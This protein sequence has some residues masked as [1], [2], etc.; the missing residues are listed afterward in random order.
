[1]VLAFIAVLGLI[2]KPVWEGRHQWLF[3][4]GYDDGIY[5]ATAKSLA[6]GEGYRQAGVPWS[7]IATKY[8]PLYPLYLSL[9]WRLEPH[10]PQTLER[11]AILQDALLPV[12]L[13]VL[14]IVL[15]QLRLSW[16]RTFFVAAMTFVSITFVFLTIRLFSELLFGCFLLA[17]IGAIEAA[18]EK[19]S[20][21]WATFGGLLA[22]LAYLTRNAALPL[23][24]A[25]P[26]FLFFRK[27]SRFTGYFLALALPMA[28]GWHVWGLVHADRGVKAPYVHE[29]WHW[30]QVGGFG[31]RLMT[32]LS[33]LS[34]AVANDFIPGLTDFLHGIPLHHLV[35]MA[36]IAGGIRLGKR[37]HWPLAM[38]FT[39]LYLIMIL[40]WWF[41]GM[42]RLMAPVLPIL[43][44]G[45]TEEGSYVARM[46]AHSIK[47][48]RFKAA[49]RWVMIALAVCLV[50]GD[51][52]AMWH[53]AAAEYALW[54]EHRKIDEQAY[55]WISGHVTPGTVLFAWKDTV[56]YLYTGVPSSHDLFVA[57]IPQS[58]DVNYKPIWFLPPGQFKSASLLLLDSD[59][60]EGFT[61]L[62]PSFQRRV[63]AVGG[64]LE[65][66]APG[67]FVYRVPLP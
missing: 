15:R 16:R 55:A 9:A 23:L 65:F 30:V 17:A 28:A 1:M 61:F 51:D 42:D 7:P 33:T 24:L 60:G 32:Q 45:I 48:A 18:V 25:V 11:A 49:P 38:I 59:F 67:A 36:A 34:A 12:Y 43:L 5:V 56:S 63:E 64:V 29:F 14:L 66:S 8:P 26:I 53:K 54:R 40:C 50:I 62:L 2:A 10:F 13:A 47:N 37:E 44:V 31:M 27:R 57:T 19:D 4:E 41:H 46:F 58:E 3:G 20:R 6:L 22:G 35:L 52:A 39:G 21:W